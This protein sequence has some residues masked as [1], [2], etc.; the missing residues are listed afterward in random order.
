MS[1]I[2]F[3]LSLL[4]WAQTHAPLF[5]S[6]TLQGKEDERKKTVCDVS[7]VLRR[8]SWRQTEGRREE[9]AAV[10]VSGKVG[11]VATFYMCIAFGIS[12]L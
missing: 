10:N 4:A 8:Q 2:L 3:S 12:V 11:C 6:L 5:P 1:A 7:D 9:D